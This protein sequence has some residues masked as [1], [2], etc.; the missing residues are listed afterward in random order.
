M[1]YKVDNETKKWKILHF[2]VCCI[3]W[4]YRW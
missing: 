1:T 3:L 2:V 4:N